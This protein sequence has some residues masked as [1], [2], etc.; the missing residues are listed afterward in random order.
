MQPAKPHCLPRLGGGDLGLKPLPQSSRQETKNESSTGE[1]C[2][3]G[4]GTPRELGLVDC[5]EFIHREGGDD[6]NSG[7]DRGKQRQPGL[8][9]LQDF[10]FPS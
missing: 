7:Q 3:R 2:Q 6:S 9:R 10:L 5:V 1:S 8:T 4:L